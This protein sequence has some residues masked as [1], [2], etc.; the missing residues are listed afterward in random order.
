MHKKVLVTLELVIEDHLLEFD[1]VLLLDQEK[2]EI[3]QN[4]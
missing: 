3:T 1:E 2:K 4:L